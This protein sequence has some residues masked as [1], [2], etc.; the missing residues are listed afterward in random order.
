M[1]QSWS[2]LLIEGTL[3]LQGTA[4]YTE[5][6]VDDKKRYVRIQRLIIVPGGGAAASYA[7]LVTTGDGVSASIGVL[8][9][10]ASTLIG[11]NFDVTDIEGW[12]VTDNNGSLWIAPRPN[13]GSNNLF[14]Y[15][16]YLEVF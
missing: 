4:T 2:P 6:T 1:S 5:L 7:P 3:G 15:Q 14:T 10:G 9:E 16:L 13:T 12:A 8:Y 11:V